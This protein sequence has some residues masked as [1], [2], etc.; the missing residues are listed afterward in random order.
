MLE[1]FTTVPIIFGKPITIWLG[2]VMFLQV[3]FQ[4]FNGLSF[5]R[6]NVK[7]FKFHKVNALVLFAFLLVHAY[8]GAGI[9]FFGF[10]Y[11]GLS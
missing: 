11:G 5:Q 1:L 3:S 4:I 7:F 10:K 2:S 8:Y 6:G 9:W